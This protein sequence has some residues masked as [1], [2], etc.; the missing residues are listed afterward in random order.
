[1][2][3]KCVIEDNDEAG[4]RLNKTYLAL[5]NKV[6]GSSNLNFSKKEVRNY[7]TAKLWSTNVNK[8][9]KEMLNYFMRMKEINTNCFYA[10]NVDEDYKFRSALWVDTRCRASYD[11][12]G[13]VVSFDTTYS[14]NI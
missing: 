10:I 11:Y 6:G 7:I 12:Y 14:T 8:N 4:I 5:A 9:V 3:A 1:M 13:D 2:H